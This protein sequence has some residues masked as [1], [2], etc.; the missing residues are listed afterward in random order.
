MPVTKS[1]K[2]ALQVSIRRA[3]EN[4]WVRAGYK[5]ALKRV[6]AVTKSKRA[7]ALKQA[8]SALDKAVKNNVIHRRRAARL[9]SRLTKT[10][11]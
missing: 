7:A 10:A 9:K 4:A 5:K 3:K 8:Q 2:K 11:A 1:A 6:S